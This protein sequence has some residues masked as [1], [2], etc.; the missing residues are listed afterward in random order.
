VEKG[1]FVTLL[2]NGELR[3]C[4]GNYIGYEPL[5]I[6]VAR[7]AVNAGFF[8]SRFQPLKVYE[9]GSIVIEIS[10]L[11]FPTEL[12]FNGI[13]DLLK[14]LTD[15][16]SGVILTYKDK[17][18]L[19]LPQVWESVTDAEEFLNLLALKAGLEQD[20]WKI[21]PVK[22]EIFSAEIFSSDTISENE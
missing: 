11:E 21:E 2:K 9:L 8:D 22:I 19:F 17:S 5:Y 20:I 4:I 1:S 7:N 15:L 12:A 14:K 16:K 10:V 13:V 6:N 3:G 18:A